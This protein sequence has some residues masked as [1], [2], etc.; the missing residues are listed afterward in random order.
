MFGSS[1]E[2]IL[3]PNHSEMAAANRILLRINKA[4][5]NIAT[6]TSPQPSS[7]PTGVPLPKAKLHAMPMIRIVGAMTITKPALRRNSAVAH[8]PIRGNQISSRWLAI[9]CNFQG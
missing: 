3:V 4:K 8:A 6:A 5:A 2:P 7:A 9:S 1:R